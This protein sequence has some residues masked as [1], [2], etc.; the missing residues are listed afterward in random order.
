VQV[1]SPTAVIGP[2]GAG[3]STL[4]RLISGLL[5]P[6]SGRVECGG[7]LWFD[8]RH[9]TPVDM[10]RV[11][12]V[13]QDYALFPHMSVRSNVAYGARV[14]V[15]PLLER[16]G[17][18]HLAKAKPRALSGGERQRVALA[19]ALAREPKLLLLDEPLSA[20]D[21]GTRGEIADQLLHT[22]AEVGVPTL[23]VTHSFDEAVSLAD[24]VVVLEH[25]HVTQAGP[26]SE[27][28]I[29]PQT[30]FVAQ[31]AGLNHVDGTASGLDV[32][33]DS[34]ER[35]RLADPANGRVAV[36]IAPWE[37]TLLRERAEDSSAQ[38]QLTAP[39]GN[40]VA[41]G[42]RVRVSVG[43][44]IAEITAASAERLGLALGETVTASFKSTAVKTIAHPRE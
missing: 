21:P 12:F 41:T 26:S 22:I 9:S 34:G 27:L 36:L 31:F 16:I 32:I 17:I 20:L 28:L 2:S 1:D 25:G 8:G 15:D 11:G 19:R 18:A 5:T 33:L 23:V 43:P 13:F 40:L 3:K 44:L 24:R 7:E 10:R 37:I 14:P 38:N 29:A 30:A 39:I 42:N 6:A 35:V 4:L